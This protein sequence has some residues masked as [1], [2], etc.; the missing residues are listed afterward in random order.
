VGTLVVTLLA[1]LALTGCDSK[2]STQRAAGDK[3]LVVATT[4][5]ISDLARQIGGDRVRVVGLMKPG[6]DPH[7]YEPRP[8]DAI[9]VRK[10]DVVLYNGLHLEGKMV[11]VFENAGG[12]A[13]ALAE[14]ERIKTRG[15]ETYKGAPDPHCWWKPQYF[16]VY[17][18]RARDALVVTDPANADYYRQR[19]AGFLAALKALDGQI[20]EAIKRIPPGQR[21]LITSHDAFYYYGDAYGL[22]VDAV[23]G[24]STDADVR[25]LRIDELAALVTE[26]KVPAIFHETSVSAS[27]N[28]MVDRVVALSEKHGHKVAV[29]H[30]ALYSDSLGER[31]APAGT[32]LGALRENTRVIVSALAGEDVSDILAPKEVAGDGE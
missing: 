3:P 16:A 5:V 14:D 4:T 17:A 18:E 31:G 25:A 11:D 9:L 20:R 22:K 15:S 1:G 19:E 13:V 23:M 29:P 26:H 28:E 21:Y 7:T 30:T 2:T 12:K 6:V 8:D 10:A 27:L 32:Y 24:I